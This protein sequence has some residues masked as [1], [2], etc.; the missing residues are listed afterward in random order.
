[1]AHCPHGHERTPENTIHRPGHGTECKDCRR[2]RQRAN[3]AK[4]AADRDVTR[5]DGLRELA[6]PR[7][8]IIRTVDELLAYHAVDTRQ[9]AIERQVV[10]YY[11]Q[12][13]RDGEGEVVVTPQSQLK[14]F[15]RPRHREQAVEDVWAAM[16]ADLRGREKTGPAPA[17]T[18][19]SVLLELAG[20]EPHIAKMAWG[21][22]TGHEDYD[23]GIAVRLME[24]GTEV[25]LERASGFR[26]VKNALLVGND[27]F[28]AEST[29]ATT[30]GT[31]QDVDTRYAK[32]FRRGVATV[33]AQ[34]AR[35]LESAPTEIVCVWGN[36]D[37]Q[38]LWN[39]GEVLAALYEGHKHVTVRNEP[40]QRKYVRWGK[41]LLGWTHGDKEKLY[42]LLPLFPVRP[43]IAA[44]CKSFASFKVGV[45]P[46]Y[47]WEPVLW[48]GGRGKRGRNE[49]TVRDYHVAPITLRRGV[50]GAKPETFCRW[51]FDLLGLTPEDELHDLFPGSG[52]VTRAWETFRGQAAL[53]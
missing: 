49:P 42:D 53:F 44:W 31:R 35:C 47:T 28:N 20:A 1:M 14:V 17:L 26:P 16:L 8:R 46:A 3:A 6:A 10:N 21:E 51:V 38:T 29:G 30:A 36:H 40:T 12:A 25:L 43:R 9:W 37:T 22:E 13:G 2:A 7:T 15:L 11:E 19:G 39:L 5:A 27:F 23:S 18:T 4:H 33:R 32:M 45:N 48:T 34:V 41:V 52:A 50:A 24:S